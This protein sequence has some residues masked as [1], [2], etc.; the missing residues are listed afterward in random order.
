MRNITNCGSKP[1]VLGVVYRAVIEQASIDS[2]LTLSAISFCK[3]CGSVQWCSF[4]LPFLKKA[5]K[6]MK[7]PEGSIEKKRGSMGLGKLCVG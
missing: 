7:W 2:S 4:S 6:I 3:S 1:H 5:L